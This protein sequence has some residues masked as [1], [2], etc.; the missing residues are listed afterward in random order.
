MNM[1]VH[2]FL[3]IA[4]ERQLVA[5]M[6]SGD[7]VYLL[8]SVEMIPFDSNL[9]DPSVMPHDIQQYINGVKQILENQGFY[10]SYFADITNNL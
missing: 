6:P 10:F 3:I 1:D 8:K 4:T 5:R 7:F 2:L 9:N